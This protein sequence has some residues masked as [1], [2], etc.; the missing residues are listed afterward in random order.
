LIDEINQLVR[1]GANG[2]IQPSMLEIK[3]YYN[4]INIS[5]NPWELE[6]LYAM[7]GA[8]VQYSFSSDKTANPYRTSQEEADKQT[9]LLFGI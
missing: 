8:F 1:L 7:C 6:C 2:A 5:R 4:E 9:N 3:S